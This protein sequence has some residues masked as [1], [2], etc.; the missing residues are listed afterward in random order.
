MVATTGPD[1]DRPAERRRHLALAGLDRLDTA[2]PARPSAGRRVWAGV[3]P[4]VAAVAIAV[5]AWQVT[6]WSG[7]RPPSLLPG[8]FTVFRAMATDRSVLL[9]GSLTTLT[10]AIEGYL[11]AM[12]IGTLVAIAITRVRGI[13]T[14]VNPLMTGLQTMPSV[15]WVPLAILLFGL[16]P[17]AV[18]FVTVIGSA[19]AFA[20]GAIAGIDA[21]PPALHRAGTMLGARGWRRYY[22]IVLP[23]ALP[24]YVTGMKQGWAFAWRSVMAAELID[25]V[26]GH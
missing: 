7:W 5:A 4:K 20:I 21:V 24:G 6:V 25:Q 19:P 16:S 22:H 26:T 3:W 12:V 1:L 23:G 10:R 15:A 11:I 9:S 8:P 2:L 14:A 17:Q 18:L 13:R